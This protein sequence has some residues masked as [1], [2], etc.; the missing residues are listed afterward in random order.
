MKNQTL[1]QGLIYTASG[2]NRK[3]EQA[4]WLK[5]TKKRSTSKNET[6]CKRWEELNKSQPILNYKLRLPLIGECLN[7]VAP[8][9][10]DP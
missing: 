4:D 2:T 1:K 10:S 7:S 8:K 9:V 5:H 6:R 3:N